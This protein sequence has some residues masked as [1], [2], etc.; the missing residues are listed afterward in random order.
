MTLPHQPTTDPSTDP[1]RVEAEE[2]AHDR[3]SPESTFSGLE[4][5]DL[6]VEA[7]LAGAA[8]AA[9]PTGASR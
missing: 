4:A 9:T 1:I 3:V 6:Y 8:F 5:V 2:R 7:F